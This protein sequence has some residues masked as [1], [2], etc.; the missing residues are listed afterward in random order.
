MIKYN[1]ICPHCNHNVEINQQIKITRKR[2]EECC[3]KIK[4]YC[5]IIIISCLCLYLI[6]FVISFILFEIT[7]DN[8]TEYDDNSSILYTQHI[9][10]KSSSSFSGIIL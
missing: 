2:E 9:Y 7:N 8:D 6:I 10:E 1:E 5:F 4:F 3:N